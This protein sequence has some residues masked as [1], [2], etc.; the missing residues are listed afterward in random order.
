M[1]PESR[2]YKIPCI[3]PIIQIMTDEWKAASQE[4]QKPRWDIFTEET[5][6]YV[7]D[8]VATQNPTWYPHLYV[9]DLSSYLG[10]EHPSRTW[11]Q[12]PI[13]QLFG[14]WESAT[15][16]GTVMGSSNT[17]SVCAFRCTVPINI[18]FLQSDPA[19]A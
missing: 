4:Q 19:G 8:Q 7:C 10:G 2:K 16:G 11:W 5:I 13:P 14:A 18:Y 6:T 1:D 17:D 15:Q 9:T 12:H 3:H